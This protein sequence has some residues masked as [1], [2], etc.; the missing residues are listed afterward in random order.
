MSEPAAYICPVCGWEG[1]REPP[2]QNPPVND[3][4]LIRGGSWEICLCCSTEFGAYGGGTLREIR[5]Y[6]IDD[7]MPWWT[8]YSPA[9]RGWN[10]QEQLDRL[11]VSRS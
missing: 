7:G 1:L 6:W 2:Y 10:A 11:L 4:T 8:E 3:D 9:P 5:Q